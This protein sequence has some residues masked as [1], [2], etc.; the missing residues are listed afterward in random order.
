MRAGILTQRYTIWKWNAFSP[1][2]GTHVDPEL[3]TALLGTTVYL[4]NLAAYDIDLERAIY[5]SMVPVRDGTAFRRFLTH[6]LLYWWAWPGRAAAALC[7][8]NRRRYD[9]S[10]GKAGPHPNWC[11]SAFGCQAWLTLPTRS[12]EV[13]QQLR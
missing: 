3:V 1:E 7:F 4:G 8:R 10:G 13:S 11:I 5:T 12:G 6:H 9:P 2:H